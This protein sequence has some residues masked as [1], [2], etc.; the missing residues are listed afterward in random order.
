VKSETPARG[1]SQARQVRM[2]AIV[3]EYFYFVARTLQKAGVPQSE[4]DDAIQRTFIAVANRLQDLHVG[5]ERNFVFQV[6]HNVAAHARRNVARR[7]EVYSDELI[8]IVQVP[9]TPE[10]LAERKEMRK[11]VND[12]VDSMNDNLRSVFT[13]Y[14]LEGMSI[15]EIAALVGVPL[16]TVA[17][18]LRRARARFR[19]HLG[20]IELAL[21][22]G[23]VGCE[24]IDGPARLRREETGALGRAL[25]DAGSGA[26][27]SASARIKTLA[28]LGVCDAPARSN[29]S[30]RQT[31]AQVRNRA[32]RKTRTALQVTSRR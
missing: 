27:N 28:A 18:R 20:A 4:L 31:P 16:G 10:H 21:D 14:E 12:I 9:T 15:V 17:S 32:R 22:L 3:D 26:F 13:L 7:R 8:D 6:A 30:S 19:Q 11:L 2:R 1:S 23:T 5:A 25:L 24:Q 29:R